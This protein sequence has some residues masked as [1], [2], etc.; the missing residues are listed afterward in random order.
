MAN[1]VFE[2]DPVTHITA[3]AVGTPGHR[4]FY[5]QAE[6]GLDRIT[7]LTEKQ[8]VE[9]L[10]EA[11]DE[12]VENLEKEFGLTRHQE[13]LVDEVSMSIK[14]PLEPLFRV[15]AMGLG[16]DANRDRILLVAQEALGEEENRDPREV[17]F[18]ATRAQM[19]ILS[20]YARD[21]IARGR[22]PEQVTLQG[23]AH[24]RRNGHGE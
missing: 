15:G 19:Q 6:R 5:I 22:S 24:G 10:T 12:M 11:I 20:V 16:Y 8:Q 9:A 21:I 3:G 23:E 13:L 2:L 7:L 4:V 14:E 1:P 17:R 18:F